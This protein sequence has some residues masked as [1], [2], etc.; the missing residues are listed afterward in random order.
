MER[1]TKASGKKRYYIADELS[2][3]QE[4]KGYTGP[5]VNKLAAFENLYEDLL[6]KQEEIPLELERL[7]S[8]NKTKT[9]RFR[10]LMVEKMM[11]DTVLN[12]FKR[13]GL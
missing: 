11:N 12:L 3:N 5:A 9:V 13:Y 7:R 2:L 4:V 1:L 8:E 6:Q 10:E